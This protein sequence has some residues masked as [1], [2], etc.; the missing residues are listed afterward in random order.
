MNQQDNSKKM[1][2]MVQFDCFKKQVFGK[3]L[4]FIMRLD[5]A[6]SRATKPEK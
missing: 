2:K 4:F 1:A 5:A 3:P 6:G